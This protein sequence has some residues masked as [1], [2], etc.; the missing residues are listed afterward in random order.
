MAASRVSACL[1]GRP[2]LFGG[3]ARGGGILVEKR[4]EA[5]QAPRHLVGGIVQGPEAKVSGL[6]RPVPENGGQPLHRLRFEPSPL[7]SRSSAR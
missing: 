1:V 5:R 2:H 6:D 4:E 7:R 3:S